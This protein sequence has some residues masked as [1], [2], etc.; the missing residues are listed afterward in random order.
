MYDT[1]CFVPISDP[2]GIS[3]SDKRRPVR[4]LKREGQVTV[5]GRGVCRPESRSV[6]Q[7]HVRKT[8]FDRCLAPYLRAWSLDWRRAKRVLESNRPWVGA[9]FE[10]VRTAA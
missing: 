9:F 1:G 6:C 5:N 7:C 2:R 10:D 4:S 3:S 8:G